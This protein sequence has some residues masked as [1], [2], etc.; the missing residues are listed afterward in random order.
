MV[1]CVLR[2]LKPSELYIF[3]CG[4]GHGLR[5]RPFPQLR[6]YGSS[7]FI[8]YVNYQYTRV[9]MGNHLAFV[10][11]NWLNIVVNYQ[12]MATI[13]QKIAET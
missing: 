5:P 2:Q 1:G 13:C 11:L 10:A 8:L 6:M 9:R 4:K 12:N 3:S 7:G